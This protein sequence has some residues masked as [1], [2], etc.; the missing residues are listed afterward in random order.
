MLRLTELL[1][2]RPEPLWR[3]VKQCG[4]DFIAV[5]LDGGEQDQRMFHSVGGQVE[6]SANS[7]RHPWSL[8]AISHQVDMYAEYG[9]T[10]DI[11]E[12]SP[13]LD[14]VRLG[15]PG[16]DEQIDNFIEQVTAM[17]ELGIPTL[18][19][20]WMAKTSWAR[21]SVATPARGGALVTGFRL[22]DAKSLTPVAGVGEISSDQLWN[23]FDYFL[24]AVLPVAEKA[25]VRLALHPDDPPTQVVRNVPR[26][27]ISVDAF[28]RVLDTNQSSSN[29]ITLCQGNFALMTD[30][31][32][33]VIREF[34]KKNALAFVHFRDVKGTAEDFVETF[35][36][37]GQTDMVA[38]M[39]AY[40]EIGYDGSI[41]P[42]HVPTMWGESN[43]R[44]GYATLGRLFALGYIRGLEQSSY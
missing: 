28:R 19:Y 10:V 8:A 21:T 11:I 20:N 15:L 35:H 14:S 31:I 2:A 37:A 3:L 5:T 41:R 12:D 22:S 23:A 24:D 17:G 18:C 40:A 6:Q 38:C 29:A 33:S 43:D 25:G 9:F 4:V 32:P 16:R 39:R 30:D 1:S 13:P 7:A 42:D 44:P 26:I 27:M 36:D 34:G